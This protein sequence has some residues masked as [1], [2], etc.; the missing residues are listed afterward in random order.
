MQVA[1]LV[2]IPESSGSVPNVHNM[3]RALFNYLKAKTREPPDPREILSFQ[4]EG[5]Q[6]K[7]FQSDAPGPC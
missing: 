6:T 3:R 4:P 2:C 7:A 1:V 5:R